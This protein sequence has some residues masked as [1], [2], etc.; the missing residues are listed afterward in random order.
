[1]TKLAQINEPLGN[2]FSGFN[3]IGLEG[4]PDEA[5]SV[6]ESVLST[7]IGIITV[8]GL[9]I[10]VFYV[11]MGAIG[12]ITAG[13]DKAQVEEARRKIFLGFIGITILI[14]VIFVV[15]LIGTFLGFDILNP[16]DFITRVGSI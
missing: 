2:S 7:A 4:G 12:I 8:V 1:M 6:F 10:F 14:A 15:E 16:A 3:D 13:G 5:L 11:L 9:L